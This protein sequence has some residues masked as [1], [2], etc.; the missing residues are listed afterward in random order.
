LKDEVAVYRTLHDMGVPLAVDDIREK[1][2]LSTPS[3][4]EA[5]LGNN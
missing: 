5:V 2:G 4:E 1:F 3:A